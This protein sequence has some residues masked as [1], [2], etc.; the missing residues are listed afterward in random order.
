MM[1][2]G[3]RLLA[4]VTR[5]PAASA[6]AAG[7]DDQH[8]T[9]ALSPSLRA[10]AA[11]VSGVEPAYHHSGLCGGAALSVATLVSGRPRKMLPNLPYNS[12]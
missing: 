1:D 2:P 3:T 7:A 8:W 5:M 9:R 12:R 10:K 4:P 11:A 6:A